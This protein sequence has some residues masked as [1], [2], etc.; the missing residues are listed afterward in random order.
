M[1]REECKWQ[2]VPM[3]FVAIHPPSPFAF[4]CSDGVLANSLETFVT[5]F[6][7]ALAFP[8]KFHILSTARTKKEGATYIRR[9][10]QAISGEKATP[11]ADQHQP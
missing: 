5:F 10:K 9:G 8:N 6:N 1:R 11:A 3:V 7:F 2:Q 4:P